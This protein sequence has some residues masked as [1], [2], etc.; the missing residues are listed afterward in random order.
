MVALVLV[1]SL[2]LPKLEVSEAHVG[3]A[4]RTRLQ[5]T[6]LSLRGPK[7]AR[8]VVNWGQL[9]IHSNSLAVG[10]RL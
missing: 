5:G 10:D 7:E 8:A 3:A 1:S 9:C 4:N 6:R 2:V